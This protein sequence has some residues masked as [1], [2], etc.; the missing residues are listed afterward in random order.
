[1]EAVRDSE[2]YNYVLDIS[3]CIWYRCWLKSTDHCP[4]LPRNFYNNYP[5]VD[6]A[7]HEWT[8]LRELS[9]AFNYLLWHT[10]NF[11]CKRF[12]WHHETRP[13]NTGQEVSNVLIGHLIA[14]CARETIGCLTIMYDDNKNDDNNLEWSILKINPRLI[15][16]NTLDEQK[17]RIHSREH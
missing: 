13:E 17:N 5:P 12:R 2:G 16:I 6:T 14:T 1:M 4:L 15:I 10:T 9:L 3:Y 8:L 7:S 11:R